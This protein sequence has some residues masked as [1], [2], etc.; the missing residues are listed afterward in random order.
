MYLYGRP[1][2]YPSQ[3]PVFVWIMQV[4]GLT[5]LRVLV[6]RAGR[7][8][9]Q[10][11]LPVLWVAWWMADTRVEGKEGRKERG[12]ASTGAVTLGGLFAPECK[13]RAYGIRRIP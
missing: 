6:S 9:C 12:S 4:G 3:T 1:R 2:S 13:N 11:S 8:T 10:P 5:Y 7:P